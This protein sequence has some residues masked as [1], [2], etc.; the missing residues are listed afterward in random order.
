MAQ[1]GAFA[2]RGMGAGEMAQWVVAL[3]S[4]SDGLSSATGSHK[5]A[6]E[7][8]LPQA[9]PCPPLEHSGIGTPACTQVSKSVSSQESK[10][11]MN[12]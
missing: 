5:V 3:V 2:V 10:E 12:P 11:I 1:R 8:W 7:K 9:V 4:G 6:G